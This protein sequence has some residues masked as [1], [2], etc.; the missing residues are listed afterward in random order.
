MLLQKWT[1]IQEDCVTLVLTFHPALY[2]RFKILKSADR[3][4]ENSQTLEA[5]SPKPSHAAFP[6]RKTLRDKLVRSKLRPDYEEERGV[7]TCGRRKFD[8]CNI[9]EPGK[10]IK[11]TTT[12]EI[13]KINCHFHCNSESAVHLLTCKICKKQYVRSTITK[14]RLCFDR[15]KSNINLY[16]EGRRNFEQ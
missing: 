16:G 13:C 5:I 14:F 10:E 15:Y 11:S 9:L 12:G 6:N 3:I 7:F 1:K 4:I 8:I 2:I